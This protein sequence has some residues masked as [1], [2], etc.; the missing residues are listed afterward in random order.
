M[1]WTMVTVVSEKFK[2]KIFQPFFT[3]KPAGEGIGLGLSLS[4][5]VVKMHG[6]ELK[7]RNRPQQGAEFI[8]Q[9]PLKSEN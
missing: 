6:G 4:Y 1:Y 9:L 7:L 2:T 8:L 3:T 5:D